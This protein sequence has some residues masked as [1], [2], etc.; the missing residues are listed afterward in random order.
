MHSPHSPQSPPLTEQE[1]ARWALRDGLPLAA[2]RQAAVAATA[3]HLHTV[4]ATL[5]ELDFMETPPAATYTVAE[6]LPDAPR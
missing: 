5:R 6:E 4:L 3:Q 2:D 1:A